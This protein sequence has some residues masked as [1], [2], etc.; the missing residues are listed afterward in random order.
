M[1]KGGNLSIAKQPCYLR[2]RQVTVGQIA[3]SEVGSKTVQKLREGEPFQGEPTGERSLADSELTC[4]F[5]GTRFA[6]GQQRN[7]GILDARS[8]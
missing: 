3:V 8:K 5:A 4:N 2:N 7:N 1:R 6:M